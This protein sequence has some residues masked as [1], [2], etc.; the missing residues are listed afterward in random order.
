MVAGK[1]LLLSLEAARAGKTA[2][3]LEL[4]TT[5]A[6]NDVYCNQ[7]AALLVQ[8]SAA[9]G[10]SAPI[11]PCEPS[12]AALAKTLSD[13]PL[14]DADD[15]ENDDLLPGDTVLPA[16]MSSTLVMGKGLAGPVKLRS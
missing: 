7:V 9:P 10:A 5:V 1:L 12:L 11:L 16:S 4:L 3:A 14:L 13:E 2:D 15:A 6:N 8:D